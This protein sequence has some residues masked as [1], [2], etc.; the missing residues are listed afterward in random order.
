MTHNGETQASARTTGDS[1]GSGGG[2]GGGGAAAAE[3]NAGPAPST[4]SDHDR[5]GLDQLPSALTLPTRGL[6]VRGER[7]L[8]QS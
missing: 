5:P 2:G 4:P 3:G 8:K 7:Y 6:P 1:S